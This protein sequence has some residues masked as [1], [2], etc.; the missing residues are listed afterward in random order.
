MDK[1]KFDNTEIRIIKASGDEE[2]FSS[3]KLAISLVNAGADR[4]TIEKIVSQII[5]WVKPGMTTH[6]IYSH[7]FQLLSQDVT[8]SSLRYRLKQAILE[9]GPTGYP[10]EVLMGK[11]F[12]QLGFKTEV[13]VVV[14]GRCVTHEIDVIA[15]NNHVQHLVECKYHKDQGKTVSIQV[16]LYVH[17]R[18]NDIVEKRKHMAE[19]QNYSFEGWVV[20][21]TRLSTDSIQYGTCC[22]LNLLA[23]NYP[24]GDGLKEKIEKYKLY[25]ITILSKLTD[26]EKSKLLENDIVVCLQITEDPDV[27]DVL[28]LTEKKRKELLQEVHLIFNN[29]NSRLI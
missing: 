25:P 8:P 15:T 11:L 3:E 12:Q 18:V 4:T 16:P 26:S 14:N 7:A 24:A 27:L 23:W 19:Y 10:F 9:L 2:V 29:S 20:T 17:S 6:E 1:N 13:G 21:N 28:L 22:G 5:H